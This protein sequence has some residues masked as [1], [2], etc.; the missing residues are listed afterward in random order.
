MSATP[1]TAGCRM[2]K[3]AHELELMQLANSAT[4]AVYEAVFRS[5]SPG[6]TVPDAQ[7]LI[8]AGYGQVGFR[9][10]AS[11]EVGAYSALPHGSVA[12]QVIREGTPV[13]VDDGCTVDG[14]QSDISRTFVLGKASDRAKHV[15]DIVH[16]AQ[17]AAL[18]AARP[19]VPCQAVDA[20]ARKVIC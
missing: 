4:L 9:G 11:F 15:F 10:F 1:V 19:G 13:I 14:Y 6:M 18:D 20:A 12:A 7:A 8:Q 2:I 3:S 16:R 17:R 5:L